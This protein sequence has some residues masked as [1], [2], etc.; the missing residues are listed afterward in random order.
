MGRQQAEAGGLTGEQPCVSPLIIHK[1]PHD[2]IP[3]LPLFL[4]NSLFLLQILLVL[5][6]EIGN[7]ATISTDETDRQGFIPSRNC[8]NFTLLLLF[9]C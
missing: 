8:N 7:S 3:L 9:S 5:I 1:R 4:A 6:N 2:G